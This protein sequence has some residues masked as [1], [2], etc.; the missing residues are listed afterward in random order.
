MTWQRT[1][2]NVSTAVAVVAGI[3]MALS[4][5]LGDVLNILFSPDDVDPATA[6]E[7]GGIDFVDRLAVGGVVITLLGTAGLGVLSTSNQNPPFL[8]EIIRNAPLIL[9]FIA[10]SAFST[11]VFEVIQ[12]NRTWSNF[13]DIAN[14]YI[15]FLTATFVSGV[16]TI[17]LN[18]NR[19][20]RS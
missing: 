9:G 11:E 13:G 3:V 14:S 2:R 1:L 10:L 6:A 17:L 20:M 15:L 19:A 16:A 8:N 7:L 18:R 4:V 12:G 5:G